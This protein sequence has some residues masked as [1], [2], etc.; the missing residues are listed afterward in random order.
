VTEFELIL[1]QTV[2]DAL[3]LTEASSS[4]PLPVFA[5]TRAP[6]TR[7]TV[8][9]TPQEGTR[10]IR[11][12]ANAHRRRHEEALFLGVGQR[13][14]QLGDDGRVF[15]PSRRRGGGVR[16]PI[17][18]YDYPTLPM[19][20]P[21]GRGVWTSTIRNDALFPTEAGLAA[22]AWQR[23]PIDPTEDDWPLD[24]FVE[25]DQRDVMNFPQRRKAWPDFDQFTVSQPK[26]QPFSSVVIDNVRYIAGLHRKTMPGY[27]TIGG[28][29][30]PIYDGETC[31]VYPGSWGFTT[32]AAAPDLTT[33]FVSG[34]QFNVFPLQFNIQEFNGSIWENKPL[35]FV[36]TFTG[37]DYHVKVVEE[38]TMENAGFV[39]A[40]ETQDYG[41]FTRG[42]TASE[43]LGT[44]P[45]KV[46]TFTPAGGD[47]DHETALHDES[48]TI[49][50]DKGQR[51]NDIY[52]PSFT[53]IPRTI[54][55]TDENGDP[56]SGPIRLID[57]ATTGDT[58]LHVTQPIVGIPGAM[59]PINWCFINGQ[60]RIA[61]T[62]GALGYWYGWVTGIRRVFLGGSPDRYAWYIDL[63]SITGSWNGTSLAGASIEFNW[64][65]AYDSGAGTDPATTSYVLVDEFES[66]VKRGWAF[67][68]QGGGALL[69]LNPSTNVANKCY[70]YRKFEAQREFTITGGGPDAGPHSHQVLSET[71]STTGAHW[72]G[73]FS[74]SLSVDGN[75]TMWSFKTQAPTLGWGDYELDFLSGVPAIGAFTYDGGAWEAYVTWDQGGTVSTLFYAGV[76]KRC[77]STSVNASFEAFGAASEAETDAVNP[78]LLS[79]TARGWKISNPLATLANL[80]IRLEG[81]SLD[82]QRYFTFCILQEGDDYYGIVLAQTDFDETAYTVYVGK[83]GEQIFEGS[84]WDFFPTCNTSTDPDVIPG[85]EPGNQRFSLLHFEHVNYFV[86]PT[87]PPTYFTTV[88]PEE[89]FWPFRAIPG[90]M[91]RYGDLLPS[92][93][94]Y[95]PG[96]KNTVGNL[97][98]GNLTHQASS[99]L[100]LLVRLRNPTSDLQRNFWT[101]QLEIDNGGPPPIVIYTKM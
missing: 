56:G 87:D 9:E 19:N 8:A 41:R 71:H 30:M 15:I 64:F 77:Y 47:W 63:D 26:R 68:P 88:N 93:E 57:N 12:T 38:V 20:E 61:S 101:K 28:A 32:D 50:I 94:F 2:L 49:T 81:I 73:N 21:V 91:P 11:R 60:F 90:Q 34:F 55:W 84:L 82:A 36:Q 35:L 95:M 92:N 6:R 27:T 79:D 97:N 53:H 22:Y 69:Q 43:V 48:Q 25:D 42:S 75:T 86:A 18:T 62:V 4:E 51:A 39:E 96:I 44:L 3:E 31:V 59:D 78:V 66:K 100:G 5:S 74:S 80:E 76:I 29:P 83:N 23:L 24:Y 45:M 98:D 89:K 52:H 33:D 40:S 54:S 17:V 58:E 85:G 67:Y 1:F 13:F 10:I 16:Q 99:Y 14:Y 46:H 70:G 65:V 72:G 37:N 7:S